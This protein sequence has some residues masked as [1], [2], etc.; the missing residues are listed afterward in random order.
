MYAIRSYY[1]DAVISLQIEGPDIE[2]F[3]YV[4]GM[5]GAASGPFSLGFTIDVRDD[6]VEL[7]ELVTKT[8]LGELQADGSIV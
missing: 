3:R 6:G 4:T 7:L 5:P 1:D 2:R 8:S